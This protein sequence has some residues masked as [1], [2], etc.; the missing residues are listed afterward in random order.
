MEK[1]S[2]YKFRQQKAKADWLKFADANIAFFRSRIKS[3][4]QHKR[5]YSIL[6]INGCQAEGLVAV[7]E[8]FVHFYQNLPGEPSAAF[9]DIDP[10]FIAI[11]TVLTELQATSLIEPVTER[12]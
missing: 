6:D 12:N 10:C 9:G 1:C 4:I 2:L 3:R 7:G 11:G 8:V 5:V